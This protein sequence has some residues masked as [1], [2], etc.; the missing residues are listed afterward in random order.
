MHMFGKNKGER[1]EMKGRKREER[2]GKRNDF[3]FTC[4]LCKKI[5]KKKNLF[6]G[7]TI[8]TLS[9]LSPLGGKN[10]VGLWRKMNPNF[11]FLHPNPFSLVLFFSL[12]I[13]ILFLL[14][15]HFD[16]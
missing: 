11:L 10:M 9:S 13:L 15:N 6:V 4:L 12:I 7:P 14:W 2:N 16:P 8:R 3:I 1:R 5:K